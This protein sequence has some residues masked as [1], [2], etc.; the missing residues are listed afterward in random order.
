VKVCF[1]LVDFSLN[2]LKMIQTKMIE[3]LFWLAKVRKKGL[4][5]DASEACTRWQIQFFITLAQI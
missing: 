5:K 2:R 1:E 4:F 3:Y